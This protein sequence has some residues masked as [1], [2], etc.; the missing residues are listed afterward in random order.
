MGFMCLYLRA[1]KKGG[2]IQGL[3]KPPF[4]NSVKAFYR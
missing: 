4:F 1:F 3:L 2:H